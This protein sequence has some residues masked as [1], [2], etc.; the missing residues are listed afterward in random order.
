M[1]SGVPA[2]EFGLSRAIGGKVVSNR[3]RSAR[4]VCMREFRE[5]GCALRECGNLT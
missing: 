2:A 1:T 3:K 5:D 4:L